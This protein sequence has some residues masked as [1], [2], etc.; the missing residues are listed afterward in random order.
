MITELSQMGAHHALTDNENQDALCYGKN[1][2]LYVI[3]LADGVSACREAK[4]GAVIASH[5]IT[6]LFLKKGT[7]FL[8]FDEKQIAD[9]ALSHVLCELKQRALDSSQPVEDYS[10]TIASVLV[11]TKTK[12]M[13]C[14]NLGD[15]IILASGNG[16]CKALC[17][18][19]DSSSGCCVTTT[20]KAEKMISVKLCD[21]GSMESVVICSDGAWREMYDRNR[22]K[23]E[24]S[25]ILSSNDYSALKNFLISQNCFDDYSFISLDMRQNNG[26]KYA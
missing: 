11:D 17:M 22:L 3:S 9:F 16:T 5:A 24:V 4:N 7:H 6:N 25:E 26:R 1:K 2:D 20:H 8:E 23:P 18:P 21:I 14:F 12:K 15:G 19:A 10:S 13:L